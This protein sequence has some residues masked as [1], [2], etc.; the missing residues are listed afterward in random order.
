M[1]HIRNYYKNYGINLCDKCNKQIYCYGYNTMKYHLEFRCSANN[2]PCNKCYKPISANMMLFHLS[3]ECKDNMVECPHCKGKFNEG[4]LHIHILYD[5]IKNKSSCS[6]C[7]K[8]F[9]I[10]YITIHEQ[11]CI[12]GGKCELCGMKL[13]YY[14]YIYDHLKVCK[15]NVV[16]CLRCTKEVNLYDMNTHIKNEH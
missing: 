4:K 10:G 11:E 14:Q 2:S 5:C 7:E 8:F 15:K 9:N 16:P 6:H 1:S 12:K 13:S 3:E